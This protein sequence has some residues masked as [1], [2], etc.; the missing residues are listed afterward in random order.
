VVVVH[1]FRKKRGL[2]ESAELGSAGAKRSSAGGPRRQR[3]TMAREEGQGNVGPS[4]KGSM[5]R[6]ARHAR[7]AQQEV[8]RGHGG[9]R[10]ARMLRTLTDWAE[11]GP[12][13]TKHAAMTMML[14][15]P[16]QSQQRRNLRR[17]SSLVRGGGFNSFVREFIF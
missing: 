9:W 6:Q 17:S 2:M 11:Q 1:L 3:E 16:L 5:H 7:D 12:A 8:R 14:M 13:S 4:G 15:M 10:I